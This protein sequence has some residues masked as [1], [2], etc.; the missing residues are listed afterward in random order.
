M[1]PARFAPVRQRQVDDIGQRTVR[2]SGAS[3]HPFGVT[4]S[5]RGVHHSHRRTNNSH[6]RSRYSHRR[7][8]HAPRGT[9]RSREVCYCSPDVSNH[10][11]SHKS[12]T[13]GT[14]YLTINETVTDFRSRAVAERRG[15]PGSSSRRDYC[16][17]TLA[18]TLLH[19]RPAFVST[20]D[21]AP[22]PTMSSTP[23]A[24]TQ[25]RPTTTSLANRQPA[26]A[27]SGPYRPT[28]FGGGTR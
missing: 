25:Y 6:C 21:P 17:G 24:V 11:D 15:C 12:Y 14:H 23:T 1:M 9:H 7:T 28:P 13:A 3:D 18:P 2:D 22:A 10:C 5:N 20:F 19:S 4:C 26:T 8:H 27:E 16:R